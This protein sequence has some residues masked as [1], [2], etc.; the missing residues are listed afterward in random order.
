M[1]VK[2]NRKSTKFCHASPG[3]VIQLPDELTLY[4]VA[5]DGQS[6]A[7]KGNKSSIGLYSEERPIT[8]VNLETGEFRKI[9]HL[10]SQVS[11]I[12]AYV[13]EVDDGDD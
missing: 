2:R 11:K 4:L 10:S 6:T 3:D 9:P 8:L 5:V 13:Q 12:N 1:Q 7:K